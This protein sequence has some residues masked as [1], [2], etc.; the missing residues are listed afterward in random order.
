[1]I[2]KFKNVK[3]PVVINS[4]DINDILNII[5]IGD[6]N[7]SI[8]NSIRTLGKS[9]VLYDELKTTKLPT[10]RFN[11][12]FE[13]KATNKNIIEP[14]GYIYLDVDNCNNIQLDSNYV[15]AFWKSISNTGYSVLVKVNNLNINN[16][17]E[18]Y[19]AI[20]KELNINLDENA[21]KPSQQTVLSYD[22]DLYHNSDSLVFDAIDKKVSNAII[23]KKGRRGITTNDTFSESSKIRF[24]NINDYFINDEVGY[25][26]FKEEKENIAQPFIP[27]R[28]EAGKRNSTMFYVLGQYAL[29]NP[30]AGESYL[31]SWANTINKNVMYPRLNDNELRGIVKSVIKKRLE[32]TLE[33][34]LNKP[35]RI[36]FNPN[37]KMEQKEKMNITNKLIGKAKTEATKQEIYN[38]IEDWNFQ[39]LGKITQ[40]KVSVVSNKSIATVKRYWSDFKA[41][42]SDLNS[43]V[44]KTVPSVKTMSNIYC[45]SKSCDVEKFVSYENLFPDST[46]Y[47]YNKNKLP[48]LDLSRVA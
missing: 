25:I 14:T 3:N 46:K 21:G 30:T 37:K 44:V 32:K 20:G 26:Y 45:I 6:S 34:N 18:T 19:I 23:K 16:F 48:L 24:D 42:I 9:N 31:I 12:R 43:N 36:L 28:V 38:I 5:K 27:K 11:F 40:K 7:L 22:K 35:R 39:F 33:L 4:I 8:I 47:F 29:L 2:N 41:Y 10:F 17:K 13:G 15:F 1:M